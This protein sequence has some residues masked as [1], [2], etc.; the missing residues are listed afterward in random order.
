MSWHV[1]VSRVVV[2]TSWDPPVGAVF[3][4]ISPA[5]RPRVITGEFPVAEPSMHRF[6]LATV[7]PPMRP[8]P[9]AIASPL[10]QHGIL[11]TLPSVPHLASHCAAR[12]LVPTA[13]RRGP[14][15]ARFIGRAT[16]AKSAPSRLRRSLPFVCLGSLRW[17]VCACHV[18]TLSPPLPLSSSPVPTVY[19]Q[20]PS[21]RLHARPLLL[22]LAARV[23]T[24][25]IYRIELSPPSLSFT[26]ARVALTQCAAI[27]GALHLACCPHP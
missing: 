17:Q 21:C 12:M 2:T 1:T 25:S 18:A 16:G 22:C 3:P 13:Q 24:P 26:Q 4:Q 27:K 9:R 5:P 19:G 15:A 8:H 20:M 6:L 23:H 14:R 7:P 11:S 10:V